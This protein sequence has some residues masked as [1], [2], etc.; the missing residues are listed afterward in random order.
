MVPEKELR[1]FHVEVMNVQK[2]AEKRIEAAKKREGSVVWHK[3][4]KK[5]DE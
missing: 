4:P 5:N 2:E 1:E 3:I